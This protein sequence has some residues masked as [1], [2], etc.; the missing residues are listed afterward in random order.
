[1]TRAAKA[2][3]NARLARIQ[4]CGWTAGPTIESPGLVDGGP[5]PAVTPELSQ[6]ESTLSSATLD[7]EHL[8]GLVFVPEP[9]KRSHPACPRLTTS[10]AA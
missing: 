6:R 2:E 9:N 5:P 10:P 3:D 1:V 7:I 8:F 4:R